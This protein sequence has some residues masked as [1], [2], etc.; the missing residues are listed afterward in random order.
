[1]GAVLL[2]VFIAHALRRRHGLVPSSLL[3]SR[4]ILA[5][6]GVAFIIGLLQFALLTYLPLLSQR[7]APDLNSGLVVMPLTILWMTLGAVT[8]TLALRVGTRPLALIGVVLGVASAVV[9]VLSTAYPAL[10]LASVLVGTAAGLVLIPLLLLG[11]HAAARD[12]VGASTSFMVLTRNFGG[13]IGA[14]GM[15]VLLADLGV[16]MA[17]TV[18]AVVVAAAIIPAL[19]LPSPRAEHAMLARRDGV[20][21]GGSVHP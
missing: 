19:L 16:N 9:L 2:G 12:D 6:V 18:L 8:G 21:G 4:V 10:L 5:T 1:V 7:V 14:A 11:Q 20:V 15:A 17:F 13:A 3:T